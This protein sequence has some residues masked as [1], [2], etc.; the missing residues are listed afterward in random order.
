[1]LFTK[2][3]N[4]IISL[5]IAT[6][7]LVL[8]AGSNAQASVTGL[9]LVINPYSGALLISAPGSGTF[10][11]IDTP[12]TGTSVSM[13]LDTVTVTDTRRSLG[14]LGAW[15][16]FAQASDLHSSTETLTANTFGYAS[17]V[18]TKTGGA[19]IVT[20]QSRSAL[21]TSSKVEEGVSI[22]GNHVVSWFPT[23]T[24][25]VPGNKAAGIYTGTITH[26]VS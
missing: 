19:V 17:G 7:V 15:T 2:T 23:I 3:K 21:D 18:H 13:T 24:I 1:M 9:T 5:Q 20:S 16:T 10:P 25:P 22:T 14:G 6:L 26:S 11:S 8:F 4:S 12:E